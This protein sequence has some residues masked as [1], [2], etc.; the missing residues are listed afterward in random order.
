M[1]AIKPFEYFIGGAATMLLLLGLIK[2]AVPEQAHAEMAAAPTHVQTEQVD[3]IAA[4][5]EKMRLPILTRETGQR[6]Q[7]Q[8]D[9]QR[10]A[11]MMEN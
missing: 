1:S 11:K 5:M 10:L 2:A 6:P 9:R 7:A 8:S 3:E 4:L